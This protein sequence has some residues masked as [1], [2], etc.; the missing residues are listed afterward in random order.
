M[1]NYR[2]FLTNF[3]ELDGAYLDYVAHT[4]T[5]IRYFRRAG[6]TDEHH[7]KWIKAWRMGE[8]KIMKIPN[9]ERFGEGSKNSR[10]KS[11]HENTSIAFACNQ[12]SKKK[13]KQKSF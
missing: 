7:F 13:I 1:L 2:L 6:S 11:A 10:K 8:K 12:C 4:H 3:R 9:E 5:H